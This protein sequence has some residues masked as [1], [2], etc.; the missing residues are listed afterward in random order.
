[1]GKS[2]LLLERH[3]VETGEATWSQQTPEDSHICWC[4]GKVVKGEAW[5]QMC[6]VIF[7]NPWNAA[8]TLLG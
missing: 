6:V 4:W 7:H 1:M 5:C 3:L 2:I 8:A